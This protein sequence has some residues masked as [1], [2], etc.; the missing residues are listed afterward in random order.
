MAADDDLGEAPSSA[1]N[2]IVAQLMGSTAVLS[3]GAL[4]AVA[5]VWAFRNG[6]QGG[7]RGKGKGKSKDTGKLVARGKISSSYYYAHNSMSGRE[8]DA[9]VPAVWDGKAQPRLL[10]RQKSDA[11]ATGL[12]GPEGTPAARPA[13]TPICNYAFCDEDAKV[14]VY[15]TLDGLDRA[16]DGDVQLEWGADTLILSLAVPAPAPAP[17]AAV[18]VGSSGAR[19]SRVRH[20][21]LHVPQLFA[22]IVKARA[23]RKAGNRLVLTLTKARPGAWSALRGERAHRDADPEHAYA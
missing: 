13:G 4:L 21:V 7:A 1:R 8:R 3:V 10:R 17:A 6:G 20:H 9:D 22:P 11:D 12:A 2:G 23:R 5:L 16:D 18:T 15:I 19:A 14:S